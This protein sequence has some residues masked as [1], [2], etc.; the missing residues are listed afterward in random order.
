VGRTLRINRYPF[1]VIGVAPPAFHGSMPALD[2]RIWAPATMFAQLNSAGTW[3]LEDRKTRMFRVLGRLA[4]G[5]SLGQAEAELASIGARLAEEHPGTN[6]GMGVSV[7]PLWRSH[8]GLQDALR[9]PLTMLSGVAALVLMI[10]CANMANLLLARA[11]DRRRELSLRMALGAARLRLVRQL[12]TEAGLLAICGSLLGLL[13]ALGLSGSLEHLVPPSSWVSLIPPGVDWRVLA[14]TAALAVGVTLLAGVAPAL[15]AAR[16]DSGDALREGGRS[17]AP[18]AYSQRLRGLLVATEMALAVTAIVVAGLFLKSF[19]EVTRVEPGFDPEHVAIGQ[20]SMAA[21]GYDAAQADAFCRRLRERLEQQPGVVAVSYADYVPLGLGKGSWEDLEVEGYVPGA[22]E[23]MKTYRS[24]VAPGYFELMRIPL[25]EGRDFDTGDDANHAPVMIVNQEFVRRFFEGRSAVGRKVRGW[26]RWFTIVGVARDSKYYRLSEAKTPYFYIPLRQVYRPEFLLSFYVRGSGPVDA[27]IATLRREA[28]EAGSAPP[29]FGTRSLDESI[30]Q[31]T[32]RDRTS[33]TLLSL[34]AGIAFLLA[35]IGLY[36]VTA[37]SVLQRR[38][39]IGIRLTLGAQR[40]DVL[41]LVLWQAARVMLVGLGV[42]LVGGAL[43][44]RS[45]KAMLF[46]VS[47]SD[48][49]VYAAAAGCALLVAVLASSVPAL[50]ALRVDPALA[51]RY[52]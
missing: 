34:L 8:Y 4:P 32:Y 19:Q 28:R 14:Y 38:G 46:A 1:T 50:R 15:V 45:V 43:V 47:P 9:A 48:A 27:A 42:G 44:A 26:G 23:D 16:D 30:R 17:A 35:T 7:L 33:A 29:L 52:E 41:A 37:Y 11:A 40:G 21:S 20:F 51:L 2:F 22:S 12:L 13:I 5:A 18:G 24:L 3:M 49:G 6:A 36:G 10:V 39:E 31:S 25:L